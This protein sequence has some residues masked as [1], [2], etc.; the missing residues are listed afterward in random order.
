MINIDD[1]VTRM[2]DI[3]MIQKD[4]ATATQDLYLGLGNG[5]YVAMAKR[6]LQTTID[7]AKQLYSMKNNLYF[8]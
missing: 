8:A 6:G 2:T 4:T 7:R 3:F 1:V 5:K